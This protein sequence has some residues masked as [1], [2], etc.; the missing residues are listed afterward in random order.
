MA[1]PPPTVP[2]LLDPQSRNCVPHGALG[3]YHIAVVMRDPVPRGMCLAQRQSHPE[4]TYPAEYSLRFQIRHC[5]AISGLNAL[6]PYGNQD[7]Q[8]GP[9]APGSGVLAGANRLA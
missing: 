8:C 6:A 5:A 7:R 1:T 9:L 2:A 3:P 4:I